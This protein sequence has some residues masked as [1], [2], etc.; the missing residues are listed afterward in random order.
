ME[1]SFYQEI[2]EL[3]KDIF[4]PNP[5]IN[6]MAYKVMLRDWPDTSIEKLMLSLDHK[7]IEVRRK[8]VKALSQFGEKILKPISAK[9]LLAENKTT[10]LS[11]LKV[12]VLISSAL[13][14]DRTPK[15]ISQVLDLAIRDEAPEIVLTLVQM[16]RQMGSAGIPF[17][18][19]LSKDDNV[20]KATAAI[21]A[22]GEMHSPC[23]ASLLEEISSDQSR[24]LLVLQSAK[25]ALE[26]Y[27]N[28][29]N[30]NAN[31]Y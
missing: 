7:D 4:H 1:E 12:F 17:L 29:K 19:S 11:C 23:I 6:Q 21:T 30:F 14:L 2:N 24:D 31:Q 18:I 22:L 5:C 28:L 16:L 3:F 27:M 13:N 25:N 26:T 9:F 20:L 8:S 15:E 10:R